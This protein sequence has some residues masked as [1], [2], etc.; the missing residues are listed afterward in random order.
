MT[1]I[2]AAGGRTW[3]NYT[4]PTAQPATHYLGL[5]VPLTLMR[6]NACTFADFGPS[7]EAQSRRKL[8]RM[9]L[10][11]NHRLMEDRKMGEG[12]R[13]FIEWDSEDSIS[14]PTY[15][16]IHVIYRPEDPSLDCLGKGVSALED[17]AK[18]DLAQ[19]AKEGVERNDL[20]IRADMWSALAATYTGS[21]SEYVTDDF[22]L[23]PP[24]LVFDA[25]YTGDRYCQGNFTPAEQMVQMAR[26]DLCADL[27]FLKYCPWYQQRQLPDTPLH[28]TNSKAAQLLNLSRTV[29]EALPDDMLSVWE[30]LKIRAIRARSKSNYI[31]W[32]RAEVCHCLLGPQAGYVPKPEKALNEFVTPVIAPTPYADSGLSPFGAWVARFLMEC[33]AFTFMYKQHLLLLKLLLGSLDV[34]REAGNGQIHYS[35]ILAGPN[36][37]SKS[38]VFTL[39]EE[40]LIPGTVDRATRRTENSFTYNRDQGCRVLIDHEMS[41][42]FFGEVH[43]DGGMRT[44]QTKEILTSHEATTEACQYVDGQRVMVESRSR[45]HLCYLAATNDWSVGQT[46]KGESTHDSALVSRFDVIFPTRGGSVE[47][48]SIMALMAADRDPS[49]VERE[50]KQALAKWVRAVQQA[51]YWLHRLIYLEGIQPVNLDAVHAVINQYST[52]NAMPPRT[53]ERIIII[54]RQC[55]IVSAIMEHYGFEGSVRAGQAPSPEHI[56]ELESKLVVTAEQAKFA[57]GLFEGDLCNNIARPFSQALRA[58]S[59]RPDPDLGFNYVRVQG[60]DTASQLTDEILMHI[61]QGHDVSRDLLAAHMASLREQTIMSKPYVPRVGTQYGVAP[62]NAAAPQRY[63]CMRSLSFHMSMIDT[64]PDTAIPLEDI[65][66]QSCH[67]GPPAREITSRCVPGHAHLLQTRTIAEHMRPYVQAG[68]YMPPES[69]CILQQSAHEALDQAHRACTHKVVTAPVETAE[70]ARRG[71]VAFQPSQ[72]QHQCKYPDDFVNAYDRQHSKKRRC[73]E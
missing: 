54:A 40:L 68:M 58:L 42:D 11:I 48:K 33:E 34:A 41:A 15:F 51:N 43:K 3:F 44:A 73:D 29:P 21:I 64:P 26:M 62:D 67:V 1:S 14:L 23:L 36:S 20:I 35:G 49:R 61:P 12:A 47:N 59:F 28:C 7:F 16:R 69:A 19:L 27:F 5:H 65:I 70:L 18:Y 37:T 63:Y 30:L 39:L 57:L 32:A 52:R 71:Y 45:A 56:H 4:L 50:G 72:A 22:S 55:C 31:S 8:L 60:C 25:S 6:N 17:A 9:F 24:E 46:S 38:Y 10:R 53:A 66:L 2:Q 13:A